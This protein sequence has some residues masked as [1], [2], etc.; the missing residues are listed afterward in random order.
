MAD[1]ELV[2][3][4]GLLLD[5]EQRPADDAGQSPPVALLIAFTRRLIHISPSGDRL[6]LAMYGA[7][8]DVNATDE[9]V[10][11]FWAAVLGEMDQSAWPKGFF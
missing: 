4:G 5:S 2:H 7:R 3:R 6:K 8:A 10:E 11:S 9:E 1:K